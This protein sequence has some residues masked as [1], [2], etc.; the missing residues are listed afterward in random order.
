MPRIRQNKYDYMVLDR[1]KDL[2]GRLLAE[3]IRDTEVAEWLG[4][5]SQNVGAHFRNATF[6]YKQIL[7]MEELLKERKGK[8]HG[9]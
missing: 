7:I 3:G 6:N 5:T 1:V 9:R 4:C 2:H 8:T